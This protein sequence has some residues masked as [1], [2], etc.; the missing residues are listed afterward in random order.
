MQVVATAAV[1]KTGNNLA[2]GPSKHGEPQA[3]LGR[4]ADCAGQTGKC[5]QMHLWTNINIAND[6]HTTVACLWQPFTNSNPV[7]N[8]C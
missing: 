8:P 6:S 7:S 2:P 4:D 5:A 1:P 3:A